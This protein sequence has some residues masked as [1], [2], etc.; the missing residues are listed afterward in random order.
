MRFFSLKT[1]WNNLQLLVFKIALISVGL[2]LGIVYRDI[3]EQHL[4]L[5]SI[6]CFATVSW[7]VVLW[8]RKML[9]EPHLEEVP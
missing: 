5:I 7:V 8:F 4:L 3:L 9:A 1:V 2:F 6:V